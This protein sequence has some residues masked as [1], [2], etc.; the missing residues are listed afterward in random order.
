MIF[1]LYHAPTDHGRSV[2]VTLVKATIGDR[3]RMTSFVCSQVD[4]FDL[5]TALEGSKVGLRSDDFYARQDE[6]MFR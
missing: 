2:H 5:S 3:E 1:E 4:W 6:A